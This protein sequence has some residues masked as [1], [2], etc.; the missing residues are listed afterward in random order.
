M[1]GNDVAGTV[2]AVGGGVTDMV[3]GTRVFG[4][5]GTRPTIHDGSFAELANPQAGGL[6]VTPDGL[7]DM[8][9]STLGVAGTTAMSAVEAVAPREGQRV[10][11]VGA[12]GGV[13][14][15][16]IQLVAMRGAHVVATVRPG[17]EAHVTDL[18]AAETVDYTGDL[19]AALDQRFPDGLDAVIDGVNRDSGR[20]EALVARVRSGGR[21]TSVVG[22]AGEA[23]EMGAVAV[24][25][26]GS[27][28]AHLATLGAL[29]V[30]GDLRVAVRRTYA[31]ADAAAALEDLVREH[32]VGK[33]VIVMTER[34]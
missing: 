21:A 7:S 3:V 20:F 27:G 22:G 28:P 26:A 23:T 12:T 6:A 11:I 34:T 13:G 4:T 32:T 9:A 10:L 14:S 2:E 1:I 33:A 15:F 16:A 18:G 31:L 29:V 19:D 17:D 24:A 25:D 5:M 30:R 8:D